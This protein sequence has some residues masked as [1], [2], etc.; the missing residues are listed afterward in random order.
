LAGK[1]ALDRTIIR[2]EGRSGSHVVERRLRCGPSVIKIETGVAGMSKCSASFLATD[3]L[4]VSAN[5]LP[6]WSHDP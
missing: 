4:T 2:R 3:V 6:G 5:A 1:S